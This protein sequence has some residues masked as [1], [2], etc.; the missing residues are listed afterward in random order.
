MHDHRVALLDH[1]L[2]Q[3]P[4]PSVAHSHL[5]GGLP[6]ADASFLG[7]SQP[8][9]LIPFLLAHR[10][11]F[12]PLALRL[13]RGTF[14]FGQLG[15][16]HFGA[17]RSEQ[18]PPSRPPIWYDFPFRRRA[19]PMRTLRLLPLWLLI[20]TDAAAQP[21]CGNVQLQLTS[22]YSLAIGSS[23]GGSAYTVT[24]GGQTLAS[25]PMTQLAL[26]HYDNTLNTTSGT[27]PSNP[28]GAAYDNGKFSKGLYLQT[29]TGIAY[30]GALLNVSEGTVEMWI[31]PRFNGS[32]PTFSTSGYSIF[33]YRASNGDFFTIAEDSAH[34]GRI[35][36]TG[37][38][39]NG[40]WESAYA[41]GGDMTAWKAG[42]WHHI[43][44]T[45]SASANHIRF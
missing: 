3:L 9:Q 39:V 5:L 37:A 22:D 13:S 1:P 24:Q 31:A 45:F 19:R 7:S 43:A 25:G 40:Q 42:E 32:D 34:Q 44:A 14:Y 30:P 35:V 12:H 18:W 6:L 20:L 15:T 27:S 10:D 36:Y 38:Q 33:T 16:S 29:G 2:E 4:Y 17:T 11:S 8:V 21:T 41:P 28:A 26:L 23:T